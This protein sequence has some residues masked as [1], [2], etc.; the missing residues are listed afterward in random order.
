MSNNSLSAPFANIA[1][2][3]RFSP[4]SRPERCFVI[5]K[6]DQ[7]I[8]FDDLGELSTL[9]HC[10]YNIFA[11]KNISM[12]LAVNHHC[13]CPDRNESPSSGFL[14]RSSFISYCTSHSN[15]KRDCQSGIFFRQTTA[16]RPHHFRFDKMKNHKCF[17]GQK[18]DIVLGG[19]QV[20][21][22]SAAIPQQ[23]IAT[24]PLLE[25]TLNTN[26][27]TILRVNEN[28]TR[29]KRER[30]RGNVNAMDSIA[31]FLTS[32]DRSKNTT[33][34]DQIQSLMALIHS[35][36]FELRAKYFDIDSPTDIYSVS[37][38]LTEKA[39]DAEKLLFQLL[40]DI[41]KC[42]SI[43]PRDLHPAE[44]EFQIQSPRTPDYTF[45]FDP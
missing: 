23:N 40:S 11:A 36:L 26:L 19:I 29:R 13:N 17:P 22:F 34:L 33:L 8:S 21:D 16:T 27:I 43:G 44:T 41:N 20:E 38:Q 2:Q 39:M 14:D 35:E 15:P 7:D 42:R 4:G 5:K 28:S 9:A 1:F 37:R 12:V 3:L 18:W 31:P 32:L 10:L 30:N 25:N 6:N 45:P 24:S